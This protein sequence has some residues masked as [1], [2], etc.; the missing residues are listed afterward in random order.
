MRGDCDP[1]AL[2]CE[3]GLASAVRVV[4]LR[5][6]SVE[7]LGSDHDSIVYVCY[8]TFVIRQFRN[9]QTPAPRTTF[10]APRLTS[11]RE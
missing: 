4:F 2:E 8:W 1:T 10:P 9:A 5:V 11:A 3:Q 7:E 6:V